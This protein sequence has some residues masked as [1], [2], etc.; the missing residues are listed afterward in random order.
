MKLSNNKSSMFCSKQARELQLTQQDK[1]LNTPSPGAYDGMHTFSE[2]QVK[3]ADSKAHV[4]SYLET[5]TTSQKPNSVF[6]SKAPRTMG[7]PDLKTHTGQEN[8]YEQSE[9]TISKN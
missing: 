6:I 4:R 8:F 9:G 7:F 1:K 2:A 5:T 3:K